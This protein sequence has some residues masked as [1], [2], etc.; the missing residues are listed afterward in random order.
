MRSMW[1]GGVLLMFGERGSLETGRR[2]PMIGCGRRCVEGWSRFSMWLT[3]TPR[4]PNT[5]R[6]TLVKLL[7]SGGAAVKLS[8]RARARA[9]AALKGAD[10]KAFTRVA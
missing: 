2:L 4:L 6:R 3:F 8:A 10:S 5:A 9:A 1:R 7:L